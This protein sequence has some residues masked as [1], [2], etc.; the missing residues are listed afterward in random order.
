LAECFIHCPSVLTKGNKQ[1][2][3]RSFDKL[4]MTGDMDDDVGMVAALT[5]LFQTPSPLGRVGVGLLL[6]LFIALWF[7]LGLKQAIVK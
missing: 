2:K 5:L 3:D 6:C 4:W 1:Y 7:N